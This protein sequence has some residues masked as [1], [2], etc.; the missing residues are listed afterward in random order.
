MYIYIYTHTHTSR[1]DF[2]GLEARNTSNCGSKAWSLI[3]P[4]VPAAHKNAHEMNCTGPRVARPVRKGIWTVTYQ[5]DYSMTLFTSSLSWNGGTPSYHP[6]YSEFPWNEGDQP[7]FCHLERPGSVWV[8]GHFASKGGRTLLQ[9]TAFAE[10]PFWNRRVDSYAWQIHIYIYI[11]LCTVYIYIY[12]YRI[13]IYIFYIISLSVYHSLRYCAEFC[14][15]TNGHRH[16][17]TSSVPNPPGCLLDEAPI[18]AANSTWVPGDVWY[19]FCLHWENMEI[20]WWYH[21]N[22]TWYH[23]IIHNHHMS[24]GTM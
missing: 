1:A 21:K 23:I 20:L 9:R 13:Y 10:F 17:F 19:V 4:R 18:L 8:L 14:R 12:T 5:A 16:Q 2:W 24:H 15:K 6:F 22:I 11:I 7:A 3:H